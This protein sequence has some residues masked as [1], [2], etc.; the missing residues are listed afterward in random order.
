LKLNTG[1]LQLSGSWLSGP[2]I[3]R[4]GWNLGV[5][6]SRILRN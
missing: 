5:N 6:L 2:P 3:I 1:G 4:M